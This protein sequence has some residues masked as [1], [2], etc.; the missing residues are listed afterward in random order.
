MAVGFDFKKR[1][2]AGYFGE[3][4]L[5][6]DTGLQTE[7]AVKLIPPEKVVNTQ[8]FFHEAQVLKAAEHANVVKVEEAGTMDDGRLY[9]AME[10]LPKGSLEDEAKGGYVD[11]SR[12][13]RI[14]IDVLRGLEYSHSQSILHRDI[15]PANIL[16]GTTGEGKLSDFGLS[17]PA[18]VDP[19]AFGMKGYV[20]TLH[21]PPEVHIG[22]PYS[23]LGEIYACGVTLY[24]LV[25]G[26]AFLPP[27]P[28]AELQK[29]VLSGK[30]PDRKSY[31]RFVTRPIRTLINRCLNLDPNKRFQ[32]VTDLRHAV[33]QLEVRLNW[34]EK[35][36]ANGFQW[37][38]SHNK[39]IHQIT[40]VSDANSDWS[41]EV[42]RGASRHNLRRISALCFGQLS[43]RMAEQRVKRLLQD[44]VLGN[45]P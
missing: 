9:V 43:S 25:N 31:R 24:R 35:L 6:I 19:A 44:F 14:M 32:S 17:I 15:K 21:V 8:N 12:A 41:I 39:K 36:L 33:E 4:W 20:Y 22:N 26:D 40:M 18:G 5:A 30:Y 16:I 10:Y 11:L 28:S 23:E 38:S 2:G 27:V 34:N 1:L 29:L 42:K 7:R 3:V 13:K 37:S 45:L